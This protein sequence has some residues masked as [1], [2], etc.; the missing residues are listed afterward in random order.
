MARAVLRIDE[1]GIVRLAA[2]VR[3]LRDDRLPCAIGLDCHQYAVAGSRRRGVEREFERRS[4]RRAVIETERCGLRF[5]AFGRALRTHRM[6]GI[7]FVVARIFEFMRPRI[8]RVRI[9]FGPLAAQVSHVEAGKADQR[10]ALGAAVDGRKRPSRVLQR[11]VRLDLVGLRSELARIADRVAR[12]DDRQRLAVFV[13]HARRAGGEDRPVEPAGVAGHLGRSEGAREVERLLFRFRGDRHKHREGH[14][15]WRGDRNSPSDTR[16]THT[17]SE[18]PLV[19]RSP[20]GGF[21]KKRAM[22]TTSFIG[23]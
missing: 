13:H 8:E 7:E 16:T 4:R 14:A 15:P 17:R 2:S 6:A 5:I 22:R 1:R 3:Q 9:G 11:P 21:K 12:L 19:S 18:R 23:A 10:I 20:R